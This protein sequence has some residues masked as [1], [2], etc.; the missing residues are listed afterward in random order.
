M[1]YNR[2]EDE[3]IMDV[4]PDTSKDDTDQVKLN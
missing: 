2:E 1:F 3:E 4:P